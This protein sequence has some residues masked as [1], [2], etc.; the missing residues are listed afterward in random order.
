MNSNP[1]ERDIESRVV[2]YAKSKKILCYKFTSP[3]KRSVPDRILFLPDGRV[4]LIEF[5]RLN[6][7]PTPAQYV[8][9]DKLRAQK[10]L[11]FVVDS[12]EAGKKVIDELMVF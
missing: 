10:V 4:V 7:K 5:K 8:E 2:S 12:V 3:N 11:V 1:L 6:C 9:I